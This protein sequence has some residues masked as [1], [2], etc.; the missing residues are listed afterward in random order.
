MAFVCC[1]F[2]LVSWRDMARPGCAAAPLRCP[3]ILPLFSPSP[4][5]WASLR[6][7][8][9]FSQPYPRLGAVLGK[10]SLT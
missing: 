4:L 7:L 5:P 8:R 6:A 2:V 9:A 10:L 1:C 3:G